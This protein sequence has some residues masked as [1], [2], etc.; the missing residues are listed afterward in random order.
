MIIDPLTK[1]LIGLVGDILVAA[2]AAVVAIFTAI[3]VTKWRSEMKGKARFE[4]ARELVGLVNQFCDQYV[5]ARNIAVFFQEY[6]DREKSEEEGSEETRLRNEFYARD[7]RVH[8]LYQTLNQLRKFSWQAEIVF[9]KSFSELVEPFRQA[10]RDLR[11]A[12]DICCSSSLEQVLSGTASDE[13]DVQG[14]E[15]YRDIVYGHEGD[16]CS[17]LVETA[18]NAFIAF[19]KEEI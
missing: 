14:L 18:S 12:V 11:A 13:R 7:K 8:Q 5:G 17:Q 4:I 10:Y 19:L 16:D 9:T 15:Q 3:G 6:S 2:S 1:E